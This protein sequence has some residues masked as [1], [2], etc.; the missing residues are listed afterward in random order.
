M[1]KYTFKCPKCNILITK[2]LSYKKSK[3][4]IYCKCGEQLIL[5][6]P[7]IAPPSVMETADK[8][9]NVKHRQKQAQRLKKR[10]KD[11]FVENEMPELI[12]KHGIK[13]S[14]KMGWIKKNGKILRKDD[15]K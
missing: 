15:L 9:R 11:Y 4:P 3:N 6:L 12:A 2:I 13:E 14:K 1:A 5:Q 10:A 8:Y 7:K